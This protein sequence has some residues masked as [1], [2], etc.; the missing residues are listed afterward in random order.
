MKFINFVIFAFFTYF[1][2]NLKQKNKKGKKMFKKMLLGTIIG[3]SLLSTSLMAN[4]N[5]N[6]DRNVLYKLYSLMKN[7][8]NLISVK[9]EGNTLI[10][11]FPD[12]VNSAYRFKSVVNDKNK[13]QK[14]LLLKTMNQAS[15]LCNSP[16]MRQNVFQKEHGKLIYRYSLVNVNKKAEYETIIDENV[17]IASEYNNKNL[18][19]KY[20]GKELQEM[21]EFSYKHLK[22]YIKV[23]NLSPLKA[24]KQLLKNLKGKRIDAYTII[25]D[26]NLDS[27]KKLITIKIQFKLPENAPEELKEKANFIKQL[28]PEVIKKVLKKLTIKNLTIM[29]PEVYDLIKKDNWKLKET[30]VVNDKIVSFT[31]TK[32]DLK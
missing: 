4:N 25:S 1:Y 10:M 24:S 8:K 13:L 11:E 14:M 31:I 6:N 28:K 17:C 27:T 5:S 29:M 20:M 16:Y 32:E 30:I 19:N 9:L 3:V 21:T 7:N 15:L 12:N 22:P 2:Y 23:K 26:T 18:I